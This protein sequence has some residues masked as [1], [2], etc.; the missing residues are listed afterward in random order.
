MSKVLSV[1]IILM[2]GF[3]VLPSCTKESKSD[4]IIPPNIPNDSVPNNPGISLSLDYGDTVLYLN[5]TGSNIVSPRPLTKAGRFY[6]FPDGI[7]LDSANGNINLEESETGLRYK[8]MFV[9]NGTTDTISTKVVLSGINFYDSIYN[10]SK[11]DSIARAIY[12]ANGRAYSPGQFGTG[13]DNVFD[14]GHGCNNQGCAVSF[15]DGSINLAQSLRSGAIETKQDAQ[16]EFTYYYRIADKSEKTLNRM[17]V[18][19]YYY[20]KKSDIPQ[21]LWDIL[22][23]DHA[24]TILPTGRPL[25]RARPRPPCII[26][27]AQ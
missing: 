14:D 20:D 24:G 19:L 26:I 6:G 11:G 5:S 8:I 1:L 3:F 18:K 16:K 2:V 9:P 13:T 22:L 23:K 21:Y 25:G 10:L 17:N 27:V 15:S 12:N 4:P 7:E